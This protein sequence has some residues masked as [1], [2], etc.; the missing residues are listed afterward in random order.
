M[1][2]KQKIRY[3]VVGLGWF[4]QS[5]ALPAFAHA[6][7]SEL[8]ALVS[9]DPVKLAEISQK[10]EGIQRTFSY[11]EYN[12][13]L[14]SGLIDAVYIA[15]PN[16]LHCDFAVRAAEAGVHVLCEKP[17]AVTEDEC[18]AMIKAAHKNQVK[19]MIAYRL[20]LEESNLQAVEI[21]RSGQIGEPRI[22]NS[23]FTQQVEADNIRVNRSVGG[24]TLNDIGIYCIN[25]ARYLFQDEPIEVF[26]TSAN[27]GEPRFSEV[28]EMTSAILRFPGDRLATF[29]CSFGAAKVSTYQIVGTKGDLQVDPAYATQ[30]DV[31]HKLTI[32]GETQEQTFPSHDQI[33]AEFVYFSD[34]I[35]QNKDPEPSGKEGLIDVRII[36][37]LD[38]SIETGNFVKL[39]LPERQQRPTGTQAIQRPPV[40]GKPDLIHAAD[41]AGK[42]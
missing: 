12:D 21:V 2:D 13:L 14:S 34:C 38:H 1:N 37:A 23:V 29:T 3:A 11:E 30:G 9:D 18:E 32:N 16:H 40:Q 31:K 39:D 22:F 27:N 26:A 6:E 17:M 5:A 15:L 24:G 7:N 33:A 19:L 42:S 4:A 20:H 41:P 8:A 10:S 36:R 28:A 35:L 25:A